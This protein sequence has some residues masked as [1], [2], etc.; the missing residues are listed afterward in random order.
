MH[1]FSPK[2]TAALL[3]FTFWTNIPVSEWLTLRKQLDTPA[4]PVSNNNP[5]AQQPVPAGWRKIDAHGKFTFYLPPNMRDTRIGGMEN[6]HGEYTS[7]RMYLS[8]D[9][10][11]YGSLGYE[12]R[13][14]KFGK[15]FQETQ[16]QI[17]GKK[18]FLFLHQYLDKKNR[19]VYNADLYVGDLPNRE[20]IVQM[21]V[22]SRNPQDIETAKTIF[23]TIKLLASE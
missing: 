13:E 8:Y 15:G 19:R 18:S 14:L 22:S 2:T 10:H 20:V 3:V 1:F 23:Q 11:P 7:G 4:A 6:I 9:Y 5:Y 21:S 12:K 17:D 16:L